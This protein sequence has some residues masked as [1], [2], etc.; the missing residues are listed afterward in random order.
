MA[1]YFAPYIVA[2]SPHPLTPPPLHA[3]YAQEAGATGIIYINSL[4]GISHPSAPDVRAMSGFSPNMVSKRDGEYL[5]RA[6]SDAGGSVAANMIPIGCVS[7][8]KNLETSNFCEPV[9]VEERAVEANV[10]SG[11]FV[12]IGGQKVRGSKCAGLF[13]LK[14]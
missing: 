2:P 7:E 6:I 8:P 9:T 11:G 14:G 4:D 3:A 1:F 13:L 12:D 10:K 5:S